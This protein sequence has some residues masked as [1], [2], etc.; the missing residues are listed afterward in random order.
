VVPGQTHTFYLTTNAQDG[1][2]PDRAVPELAPPH[3]G[4]VLS[5]G[6]LTAGRLQLS[7]AADAAATLGPRSGSLVLSFSA[8]AGGLKVLNQP[9]TINIVDKM[10][11]PAPLAPRPPSGGTDY[12]ASRTKGQVALLWSQTESEEGWT[13]DTAGDLQLVPGTA[14]TA[15]DPTA[16]AAYKDITTPIPT[17]VI[18]K[19][20]LLWNTYIRNLSASEEIIRGRRDDYSV[21]LGVAIAELWMREEKLVEARDAWERRGKSGEEPPSAM[22]VI[23]RR[24]AISIAARG[25]IS[26]LPSF[27]RIAAAIAVT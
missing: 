20:F 18:N 26:V 27:D 13:D 12:T 25:I 2:I 1:F 21:A 23:Q 7:I 22:T 24:R 9:L 4:L 14:L 15:A 19:A 5:F 17:V 6:Y 11:A 16:Y 8:R 10:P 3:R